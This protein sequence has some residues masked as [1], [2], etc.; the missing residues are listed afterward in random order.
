MIIAIDGFA[1]SG[2][3]TLAR[4][5]AK[6]F[7]IP[8]LDTGLLYRATALSL[9]DQGY[10]LDDV[11][12]AVAVARSLALLDFD[13][14]RLRAPSMGESASRVAAF[15]EVREALLDFQRNFAHRPGG[16]ILDGRDI[17]TVICPQADIKI[18]VTASAET[19]AQRRTLELLNRGE[20]V[21]YSHVLQDI[22]RRDERDTLRAT[23]PLMPSPEALWLDTSHLSIVETLEKAL[24]FI[25]A[26]RK[27]AP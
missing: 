16:A 3:G 21:A 24:H 23:A 13:E 19:R 4:Q 9:L 8:Y 22:H 12:H 7:S 2:K 18:F 5:L 15:P 6:H 10:R 17:G 20:K 11:P 1:A 26:K 14:E 25:E 27:G